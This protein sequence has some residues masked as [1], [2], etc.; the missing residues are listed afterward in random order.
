[1]DLIELTKKLIE[2]E[3]IS[4]NEEKIAQFIASQLDFADI[5]MQKVEGFGPNVIAKHITNPKRPVIILNC[6]MDTVEV[7]QGWESDPFTPKIE[8]NRLYGLGACDMKAGCAIAM[9]VFKRV[10]EMDKNIVFTAVSDEEGNSKGS[11]FC[12]KR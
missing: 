1:M 6:H 2:I 10:K 5:T 8:G 3:S 7:M 9:E 11:M 4:S 12:L